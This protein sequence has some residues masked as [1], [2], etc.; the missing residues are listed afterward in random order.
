MDFWNIAALDAQPL[1]D[2]LP[3]WGMLSLFIILGAVWGSFT[4][5]LAIRWPQD[6][7]IISGRS[8][9]DRCGRQ[10]RWFEI[11]PLLSFLLSRGRCRYCRGRIDIVHPV[12]EISAAMIGVAACYLLPVDR[13]IWVALFG[14]LLLPLALLDARHLWLPDPLIMLL[15]M[16]GGTR[17]LLS[18]DFLIPVATALAGFLLLESLRQLFRKIRGHHGMGAGDPKL[19]AAILLWLP[20]GLAPYVILVASSIGIIWVLAQRNGPVAQRQIPFGTCLAISAF[21]FSF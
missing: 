17:L 11:V 16:I 15:A 10:L 12:A 7:S 5:A 21:L 18:G 6:R 2:M 9:C 1:A 19:L 4:G 20:A 13:A 3:Y 8:A 14:W